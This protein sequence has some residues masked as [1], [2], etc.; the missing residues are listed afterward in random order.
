MCVESI[1]RYATF[2][3]LTTLLRYFL[4]TVFQG[5]LRRDSLYV[6]VLRVV[7]ADSRVPS[8]TLS[9]GLLHPIHRNSRSCTHHALNNGATGNPRLHVLLLLLK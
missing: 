9:A 5:V 2:V 3:L 8:T 7:V 6:V 1:G 4:R